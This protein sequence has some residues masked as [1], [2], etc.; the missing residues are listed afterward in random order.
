MS[1]S[2]NCFGARC[3]DLK[4]EKGSYI[5]LIKVNEEFSIKR[6]RFEEG[7]YCY[8]GS[9]WGTGGLRARLNRHFSRKKRFRWHV[10]YLLSRAEPLCAIIFIGKDEDY[11]YNFAL[12]HC[13]PYVRGFGST[14]T[15]HLTHLFKVVNFDLGRSQLAYCKASHAP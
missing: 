4:D 13:K 12:R 11:A 14:D 6:W 5:L 2:S 10:D 3:V 15:N 9:A 1:L 7:I 8:V